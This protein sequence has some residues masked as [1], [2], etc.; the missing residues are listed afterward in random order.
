M[1]VPLVLVKHPA[2]FAHDTGPGHPEGPAR[3]RGILD[4]VHADADLG[5][6]V[7]VEVD[8]QPALTEDLVQAHSADHVS[9]VR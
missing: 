7:L 1:P 4:A 2:C 6:D 3:L 8:A 5:R 9:F